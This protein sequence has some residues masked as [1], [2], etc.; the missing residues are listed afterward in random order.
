MLA[1]LKPGM[2]L[3]R[4]WKGDKHK[5]LVRDDGFEH[6]GETFATLSEVARHISEIEQAKLNRLREIWT[7]EFGTKPLKCSRSPELFRQIVAWRVQE[8]FLGGL[9]D[10]AQQELDRMVGPLSS[11]DTDYCSRIGLL[12]DCRSNRRRFSV[13]QTMPRRQRPQPRGSGRMDR[14]PHATRLPPRPASG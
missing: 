6:K 2:V 10:W 8:K 11:L 14:L 12:S 9:S 5:V 4:E 3:V 13:S 1:K 7:Q